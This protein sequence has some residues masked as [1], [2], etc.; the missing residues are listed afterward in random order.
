MTISKENEKEA[1][2]DRH[3]FSKRKAARKRDG[4]FETQT[5]KIVPLYS[6][7]W[8]TARQDD[9]EV[10]H[11]DLLRDAGKKSRAEDVRTQ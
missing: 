4:S 2:H 1:I 5:F 8:P 9:V 10:N 6:G 7:D 11:K 3:Q